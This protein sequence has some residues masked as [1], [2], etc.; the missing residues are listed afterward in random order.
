MKGYAVIRC[1]T[2][3]DKEH[4]ALLQRNDVNMTYSMK[5]FKDVTRLK[6]ERN[7]LF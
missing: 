1:R 2:K 6:K 3:G 7:V 4:N 5:I